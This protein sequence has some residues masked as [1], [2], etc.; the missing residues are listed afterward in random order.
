[1]V[2]GFF[3]VHYRQ[4]HVFIF[5]AIFRRKALIFDGKAALEVFTCSSYH[6]LLLSL[7][8]FLWLFSILVFLGVCIAWPL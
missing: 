8:F 7:I 5:Y 2:G 4:G 3:G 6:V 1:M